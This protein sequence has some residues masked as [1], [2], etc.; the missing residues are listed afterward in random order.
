MLN[1]SLAEKRKFQSR[2]DIEIIVG[3]FYEKVKLDP[4]IGP[5]FLEQTKV[6]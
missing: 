1:S 3:K 5:V 2:E 6:D 4:L